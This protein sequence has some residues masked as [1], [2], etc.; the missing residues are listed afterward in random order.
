MH[1]KLLP[2]ILILITGVRRMMMWRRRPRR[3][4]SLALA[5]LTALGGP[6]L[7]LTVLGVLLTARIHPEIKE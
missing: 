7:I 3:H 2:V 1:L 6:G 4:G 5:G